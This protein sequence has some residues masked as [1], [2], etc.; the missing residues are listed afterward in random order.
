MAYTSLIIIHELGHAFAAKMAGSKI[1]AV[2]VVGSGGWCLAALSA[3]ISKQ[4]KILQD[5]V[6]DKN[7]EFILS[8][9]EDLASIARAIS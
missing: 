3:N 4:L 7:V 5:V 8:V 2:L 9:H 1:H 6:I